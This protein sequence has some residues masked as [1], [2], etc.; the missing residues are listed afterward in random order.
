MTILNYFFI[1]IIFTFTLDFILY[2]LQ[3]HPIMFPVI[4]KWDN[5]TRV[6]CVI[7]WPIAAIVF[8]YTFFKSFFN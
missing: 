1:G 4:E 2:Q 3:N 7:V 6:A 8:I 5:R